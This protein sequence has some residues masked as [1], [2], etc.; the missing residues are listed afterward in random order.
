MSIVWQ[1]R[2]IFIQPQ[3]LDRVILVFPLFLLAIRR[4]Q[5]SLRR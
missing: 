2:G 1:I 5:S 3:E 4:Y